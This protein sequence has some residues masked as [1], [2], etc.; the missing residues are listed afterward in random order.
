[1]YVLYQFRSQSASLGRVCKQFSRCTSTCTGHS[2]QKIE[3]LVSLNMH[4]AKP[5]FIFRRPRL[6][7][8]AHFMNAA[9]RNP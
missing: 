6:P 1:M 7:S 2:S 4:Q 8:L 5:T 3:E 9:S